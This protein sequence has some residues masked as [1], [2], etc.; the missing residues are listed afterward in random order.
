MAASEGIDLAEGLV[1]C[2]VCYREAEACLFGFENRGVWVGCN[3]SPECARYIEWHGPH[4][5]WTL[6]MAKKEW[7]RKNSGMAGWLR[8]VKIW[9]RLHGFGKR[10]EEKAWEKRER[11]A[12]KAAMREKRRLAKEIMARKREKEKGK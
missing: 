12:K 1:R 11:A 10:E 3:F 8:R 6:T 5:G 2:P 4:E 7:N 9:F